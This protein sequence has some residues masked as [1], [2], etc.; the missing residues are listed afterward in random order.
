MEQEIWILKATSM[1]SFEQVA[2]FIDGYKLKRVY[3]FKYP[4]GYVTKDR[5]L[6]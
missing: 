6:D 2:F 5:K 1:S 4:R 3:F